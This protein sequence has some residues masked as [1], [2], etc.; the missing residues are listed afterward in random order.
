MSGDFRSIGGVASR[1]VRLQSAPPRRALHPSSPSFWS[2]LGAGGLAGA[3][4]KLNEARSD[5]A[6]HV[7]QRP[8]F[9]VPNDDALGHRP[10]RR[11]HKASARAAPRAKRRSAPLVVVESALAGALWTTIARRPCPESPALREALNAAG[12]RGEDWG[13]EAAG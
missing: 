11:V 2:D 6:H 7:E 3:L 10:G 5:A 9:Q 4:A 1:A 13:C 8:L 12:F